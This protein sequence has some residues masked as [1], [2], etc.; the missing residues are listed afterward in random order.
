MQAIVQSRE[1][2]S[3]RWLALTQLKH[4]VVKHW[5]ASSSR[6]RALLPA[7]KAWLADLPEQDAGSAMKHRAAQGALPSQPR[8]RACCCR[9]QGISPEE[10]AHVRSNLLSVVPQED[11]KVRPPCSQMQSSLWQPPAQFCHMRHPSA[12]AASA[13]LVADAAQF[14]TQV[15]VVFAKIARVDFPRDWP[16]LF[17]D[18]LGTLGDVTTLLA[19][20][21]F[22]VL[23]HIL[24]ELTTKRL[25]SD[26]RNFAEVGGRHGLAQGCA[27]QRWK[28]VPW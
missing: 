3:A 28:F 23:H 5:R 24:K 12:G 10:K 15:A 7:R 6:R 9:A 25:A 2:Y 8:T 16:G 11:S 27:W 4:C 20:R 13:D 26:Q 17:Q 18:L 19:R 21:T 1:D 22:L 14:A